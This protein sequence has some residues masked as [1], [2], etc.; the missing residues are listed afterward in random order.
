[1]GSEGTAVAA[2][3]V[4]AAARA[5]A[6][7]AEFIKAGAAPGC[8]KGSAVVSALRGMVAGSSAG[9]AWVRGRG[10]VAGGV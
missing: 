5:A 4:A 10:G 8:T 1:M 6:A 9:F 3:R 2:D 7:E